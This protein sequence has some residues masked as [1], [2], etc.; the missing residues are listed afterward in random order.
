MRRRRSAP[1]RGHGKSLVASAVSAH[2]ILRSPLASIYGLL[3]IGN[4]HAPGTAT[5]RGAG[6]AAGARRGAALR[7]AAFLRAGRRFFAALF[8]TLRFA[9]RRFTARF[10]AGF[11][12]FLVLPLPDFF[13]AF[14][15]NTSCYLA[16]LTRRAGFPEAP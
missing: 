3:P 5:G 13:L 16:S 2:I 9:A 12:F 8:R 1:H 11:F 14:A 7:A 15:I 6:A 10:F 4:G